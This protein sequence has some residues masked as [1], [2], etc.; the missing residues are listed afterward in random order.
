MNLMNQ[1]KD[2]SVSDLPK[3]NIK[4]LCSIYSIQYIA[5]IRMHSIAWRVLQEKTEILDPYNTSNYSIA[6]ILLYNIGNNK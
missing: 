1:F 3:I 5:V 6:W 2:I 4:L